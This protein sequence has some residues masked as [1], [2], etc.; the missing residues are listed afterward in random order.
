MTQYFQVKTFVAEI[1]DKFQID[2]LCSKNT[3]KQFMSICIRY[4]ARASK[5]GISI[6][7]GAFMI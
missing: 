4:T 5:F 3:T 6:H 2:I 1:Q 7:D